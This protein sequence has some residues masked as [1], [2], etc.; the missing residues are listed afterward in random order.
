MRTLFSRT[1]R[2]V[3][4]LLVSI[5]AAHAQSRT[6]E[7]LVTAVLKA[8]ETRNTES[9]KALA[10]SQDEI[11]RF[12][13]PAVSVN[14]TGAGMNADKFAAGYETSNQ[15]GLTSALSEFGGKKLELVKVEMPAPQK[16]S[17]TTTLFPAP[18]IRVR[19]ESGQEKTV[20]IVG[21][22]LDQNGSYKVTTYYVSPGIR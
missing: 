1:G 17:G 9:L 3:V 11:K 16:K 4:C 8:L 2:I 13:W 21:G 15:L 10:L 18:S 6:P 7:E 5:S 22:I 12:V 19:D 14:M 20:R